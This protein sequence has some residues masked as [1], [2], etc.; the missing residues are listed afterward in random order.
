VV[1]LQKRWEY[2]LDPNRTKDDGASIHHHSPG[3]SQATFM[4]C[5][6]SQMES[7]SLLAEAMFFGG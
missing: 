7:S 3:G 1:T 6:L 4:G 5:L 2:D